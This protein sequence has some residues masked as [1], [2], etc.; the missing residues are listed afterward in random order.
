MNLIKF[1]LP[2]VSLAGVIMNSVLIAILPLLV[3]LVLLEWLFIEENI[4]GQ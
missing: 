3:L 1:A 4:N 2:I